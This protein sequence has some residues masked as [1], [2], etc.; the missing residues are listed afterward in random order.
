MGERD[1]A[2]RS[3]EDARERMSEIAEE[4]ARRAAPA[5]LK[6]RAKE[7]AVKK[8][9]EIRDRALGSPLVLGA[10]GG[11]IGWMAGAAI[12]RKYDERSEGR[13][14]RRLE[15]FGGFDEPAGEYTVTSYTGVA[16]YP[17]IAPGA[18]GPEV[19]DVGFASSPHGETPYGGGDVEG[20]GGDV[21]GEEPGFREKVGEKKEQLKSKGHE[22][23]EKIDER[24]SGGGEQLRHRAEGM[25]SRAGEMVSNVRSHLPSGGEIRERGSELFHRA[26]NSPS[27]LVIGGL[28]IGALA[29]LSI[30]VTDAERRSVRPMK[31]K[32]REGLRGVGDRIEERIGGSS[33]EASYESSMVH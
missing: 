20:Y 10:F 14:G 9:T 26:E 6:A 15:G 22:L 21:P 29:A 4:L 11:A 8:G 16:A 30:P 19:A 13:G 27:L 2:R 33:G 5:Q 25:K 31:A 3:I 1:D 12:A 18:V 23:R 7:E 17:P 32:A 24:V 28:V